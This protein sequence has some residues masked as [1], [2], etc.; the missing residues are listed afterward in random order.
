MVCAWRE[1]QA[2]DRKEITAYVD[3]LSLSLLLRIKLLHHVL[4][5]ITH[6]NLRVSSRPVVKTSSQASSNQGMLR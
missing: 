2:T 1:V 4:L 6:L 5:L 3:L